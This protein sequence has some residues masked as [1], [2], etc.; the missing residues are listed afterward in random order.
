MSDWTQTPLGAVR[1]Y[2]GHVTAEVRPASTGS[3][4]RWRVASHGRLQ[5]YGTEA[6]E[7]AAKA[8]ATREAG[9]RTSE[10]PREL[11]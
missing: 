7:A 9:V 3:A 4:Y 5:R 10:D 1:S 2:G 11:E 8:S 6:T